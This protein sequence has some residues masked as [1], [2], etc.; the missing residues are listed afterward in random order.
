MYLVFLILTTQRYLYILQT[1]KNGTAFEIKNAT[2]VGFSGMCNNAVT[3]LDTPKGH[4]PPAYVMAIESNGHER[5]LDREYN[6]LYVFQCK[7]Q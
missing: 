5:G 6:S 2:Q 1:W 7:L 3:R 4:T